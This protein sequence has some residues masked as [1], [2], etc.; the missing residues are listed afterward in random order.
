MPALVL[1]SLLSHTLTSSIY[2]AL[3][4]CSGPCRVRESDKI[5]KGFPFSLHLT[6]GTSDI[7][8]VYIYSGY[9]IFSNSTNTTCIFNVAHALKP[10][11]EIRGWVLSAAIE[12]FHVVLSV[13]I[14]HC[15]LVTP[16]GLTPWL[17]GQLFPGQPSLIAAQFPL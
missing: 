14:M 12:S 10:M 6:A 2:T 4:K 3:P 1:S 17:F 5:S 11:H 16:A 7:C 13:A 8:L 9:S 15:V